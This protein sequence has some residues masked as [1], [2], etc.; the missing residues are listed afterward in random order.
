MEFLSSLRGEG[1]RM[2]Q[3][4]PCPFCGGRAHLYTFDHETSIVCA[5]CGTQVKFDDDWSRDECVEFFNTRAEKTCYAEY[6]FL[7]GVGIKPA[8]LFTC[9]NCEHQS[10]TG[11]L[12]VN[13]C[14][15]CGAKVIP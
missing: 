6:R 13:F 7:H 10:L 2:R 4:K 15:V 14:P 12:S 11:E 9:S 3:L 1:D 8:R 5:E